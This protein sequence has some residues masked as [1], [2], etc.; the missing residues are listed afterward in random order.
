M[1]LLITSK[2][3]GF[4]RA[5]VAHSE[6]AT[7]WPDGRF[8]EAQ[9]EQ[10]R[11][12][13]QLVVLEGAQPPEALAGVLDLEQDGGDEGNDAPGAAGNS[14]AAPGTPEAPTVPAPSAAA[15]KPV[16]AAKGA[17][18]PKAAKRAASAKPPAK[19][20]SEPADQTQ[21]TGTA[22]G[23]DGVAQGEGNG[24]SNE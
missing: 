3:D 17:A 16:A 8:T 7:Y 4:R 19:D 12:E 15:A 22:E 20:K 24:G 1:G 14:E 5:G 23:A 10:L 13:P 11:N 2:R 21:G 6:H 18:K 9:L